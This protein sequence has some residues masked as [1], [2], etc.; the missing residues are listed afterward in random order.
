MVVPAFDARQLGLVHLRGGR[1]LFLCLSGELPN[2][3]E[4]HFKNLGPYVLVDF[5]VGHRQDEADSHAGTRG[6]R[7]DR[8]R[9]LS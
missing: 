3:A 6:A 7:L 4:V 5:V 8:A 9:R 2:L 1:E